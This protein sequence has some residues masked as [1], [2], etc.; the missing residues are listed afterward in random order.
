VATYSTVLG[1]KLNQLSDPFELSDFVANW[2]ILD[3]NPG[4]FICTSVSKPSWGAAQAGRMIF[5]TDLKQLSW[6]SGTAWNDLRDSA[7]VFAG[8]SYLS[9]ACNPGSTGVFNVL[10]FTTPR[11]SS[12]AIWLS[13]TYNCPNNKSQNSYQSVVFDGA[14]QTIGSFREQVRFAGIS[15]DTGFAVGTNAASLAMIP[16]VSA[17]Q[18]RI[19]VQVD[20]SSSYNTAITLVGVKVMAMIALY[21]TGNSL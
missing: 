15:G 14:Q 18:H 9:V 6:W 12:L 7:P 4:Y 3:A 16:T 2:S 11:P 17:G 19:G 20:V 1:L 21:A 13:G 10:T 5:M 8:G